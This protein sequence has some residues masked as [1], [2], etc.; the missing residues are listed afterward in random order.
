MRPEI[1]DLKSLWL[2][3]YSR[4]SLLQA[5]EWIEHMNRGISSSFELRALVTAVVVAYARPFTKS[6]VTPSERMIPLNGVA[7]PSELLSTHY[8]ILDFRNKVIGHIDA[9]PAGGHSGTPNKVLVRR[10]ATG[11]DLHT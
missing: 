2:H 6:Q 11:F 7:P 5:V 3:A 1:E 8:E 9:L 4:S 10:D